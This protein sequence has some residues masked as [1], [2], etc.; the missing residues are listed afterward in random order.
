MTISSINQIASDQGSAQTLSALIASLNISGQ[1][2]IET[3]VQGQVLVGEPFNGIYADTGT[4]YAVITP[5][6]DGY[7]DATVTIIASSSQDKIAAVGITDSG[8]VYG[9]DYLSST[10]HLAALWVNGQETFL[11]PVATYTLS[12]GT[13]FTYTQSFAGG[14]GAS[15]QIFGFSTTADGH[16]NLATIWQNGTATALPLLAGDSQSGIGSINA[17]G[18]VVGYSQDGVNEHPVEWINGVVQEL[19]EPTGA[20]ASTGVMQ[21][22]QAGSIND[23]GQILGL[24]YTADTSGGDITLPVLWQ[25]G[26]L[27]DLSSYI[28]DPS[29]IGEAYV[30]AINDNG[31]FTLTWFD[32]S[33]HSKLVT[34]SFSA[35]DAT[36][37]SYFQYFTSIQVAD[38]AANIA[39][40]LNGL[41][42]LAAAGKIASISLIDGGIPSLSISA[43]QLATDGAALA[44]ITS[45]F[46]I[47]V[48]APAAS[49]TF[50]GLAGHATTIVFSGD[51]SQY[52]VEVSQGAAGLTVTGGG[53]TLQLSNVTAL[54]F[55]DTTE[56]VAQTPGS[57]VAGNVTTGNITELYGAVFGRLPD[58]AGLAYYQ[59]VLAANPH[60]SL[61]T[62]AQYFIASPEYTSN[63]AHGY[64]QT[65]AGEA[66]FI[67]DS[68]ENLLQRAPEAGAIP[69]YQNAIN[70]FTSGLT[71]GTAAYASADALAHATV[72]TY[73]SQSTEFL[74]D[75]QVTAQ[76]PASPGFSG[77][78]LVLV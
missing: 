51:A 58:T 54:Q 35:A 77:H 71:P 64:A 73:F 63:S 20:L 61:V 53:A 32:S 48:A 3:N 34:L 62:F 37:S 26:Q 28:P 41:A 67:T 56:I 30:G 43:A 57:G 29:S 13:Q 69:F 4:S 27:I 78:W 9:A 36:N 74:N 70:Q 39:T 46:Q 24:R 15:G 12:D 40:D 8:L 49:G 21:G 11:Q 66:Q 33:Q 2:E 1:T 47:D 38:S 50:T 72:L 19:A 60:L 76:N 14:A 65:S 42:G 52:S 44:L 10:A 6:S 59:G 16:F 23:V 75:V 68:Y 5:G 22:A 45:P 17:A 7:S 31:Q 55:A 25:N 18:V